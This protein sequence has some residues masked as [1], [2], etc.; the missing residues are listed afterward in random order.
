VALELTLRQAHY[1]AERARR[2][3]DAVEPE[4]RLVAD[5]LER[6][7]NRALEEVE[8]VRA[9]LARIPRRCSR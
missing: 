1:E 9:D 2:Q 4:N 8:R 6:R 5:E 3:Y 7:W